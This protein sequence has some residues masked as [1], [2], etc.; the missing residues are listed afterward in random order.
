MQIT[1][2]IKP[3]YDRN[4]ETAFPR[5][6]GA[7]STLD[8]GTVQPE[9][10]LYQLAG[11]IDQLLYRLDGTRLREVLFPHKNELKKICAGVEEEI[12]GRNLSAADKWLYQLEDIFE[13]IEAALK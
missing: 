9:P 1:V 3:F 11:Q 2:M 4:F 6:A 8:P 5:L 7:L 12:A 13:E 10:S